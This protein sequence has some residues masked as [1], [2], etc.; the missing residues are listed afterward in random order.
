MKRFEVKLRCCS[1][2]VIQMLFATLGA[3]KER[4][5]FGSLVF[6][7]FISKCLTKDT[8][9]QPTAIEMLKHKFIE[10]CK[11]GASGMLPRI[12][13]AKQIGASMAVQAH[14]I[15]SG[16]IVS[17][18]GALENPISHE[19]IVSTVPSRPQCD[20]HTTQCY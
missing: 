10:K 4:N 3:T 12:E 20:Q 1:S 5:I 9:L 7:D 13:K 17:R 2:V 8:R 11:S 14:D 15:E 19:A 18:D 16:T 6:H